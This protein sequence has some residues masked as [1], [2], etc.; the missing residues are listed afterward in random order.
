MNDMDTAVAARPAAES[1]VDSRQHPDMT[2]IAGGTFRMGS[3]QH[4]PEDAP[5]NR[6]TVDGCFMDTKPVTNRDFRKLI[7]AEA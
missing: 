4:Y 2:F 7:D 3:D 6:V 5:V 1:E